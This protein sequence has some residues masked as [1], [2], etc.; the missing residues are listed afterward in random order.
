MKHDQM[1]LENQLVIL[2]LLYAQQTSTTSEFNTRQLT[3]A[4]NA[5]SRRLANIEIERR[6]ATDRAIERARLANI[7]GD[8]R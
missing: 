5:T 3:K 4:I 2:N 7:V 6:E 8:G 1:I